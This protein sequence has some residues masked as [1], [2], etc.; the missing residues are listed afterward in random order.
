MLNFVIILRTHCLFTEMDVAVTD[1]A[2]TDTTGLVRSR[3][4]WRRFSVAVSILSGLY[5]IPMV[6]KPYENFKY[7]HMF[8]E[9][10]MTL[11]NLMN[12][13]GSAV[14]LNASNISYISVSPLGRA[15]L[16]ITVFWDK[17]LISCEHSSLICFL[18]E[19]GHL[20]SYT[21]TN[22]TNNINCF[23]LADHLECHPGKH[24]IYL[25]I[26]YLIPL[27]CKSMPVN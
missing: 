18:V 8:S 14:V 21:E 12:D 23:D 19:A 9:T 27:L 15:W 6:R 22:T 3:P 10:Q 13:T 24:D 7:T 5:N 11:E 17:D 25:Y 26:L 1:V 16:D 2:Y 4:E 20:S